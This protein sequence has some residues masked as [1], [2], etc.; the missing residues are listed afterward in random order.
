MTGI[1]RFKGLARG[2]D[3]VQLISY[4][5]RA[6]RK[7]MNLHERIERVI[8]SVDVNLGT[9]ESKAEFVRDVWREHRIQI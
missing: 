9:I 8:D 6:M 1:K 7:A 4:I 5:Q 2:K 3:M